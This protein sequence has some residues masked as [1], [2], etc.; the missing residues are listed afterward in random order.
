MVIIGIYYKPSRMER[1]DY[2]H[3]AKHYRKIMEWVAS[4]RIW[5]RLNWWSTRQPFYRTYLVC[6]DA[7][8]VLVVYN[9]EVLIET[10]IKVNSIVLCYPTPNIVIIRSLVVFTIGVFGSSIVRDHYYS[11]VSPKN[12]HFFL[13]TTAFFCF[14]FTLW[15]VNV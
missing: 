11:G 3:W 7:I 10:V 6:A 4:E 13:I 5:H 2:I 15:L 14:C 12:F 1:G 9:D 8:H